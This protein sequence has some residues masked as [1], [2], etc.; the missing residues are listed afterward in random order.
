[1]QF[2]VLAVI[3]LP[4]MIACCQGFFEP[5]N[6]LGPPDGGQTT[7]GWPYQGHLCYSCSCLN[8]LH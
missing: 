3:S 5:C 4:E 2:S 8:L 7:W 6:A 1:M